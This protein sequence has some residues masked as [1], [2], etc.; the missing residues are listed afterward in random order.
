MKKSIKIDHIEKRKQILS[1][2]VASYQRVFVAEQLFFKKK[3]EELLEDKKD[4]N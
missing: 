2:L 1:S 4:A 3:L